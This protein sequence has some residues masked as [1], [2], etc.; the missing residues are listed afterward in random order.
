MGHKHHKEA[1]LN[2]QCWHANIK[3]KKQKSRFESVM[4]VMCAIQQE[5]QEQQQQQQQQEQEQ[6]QE[7]SMT[8]LYDLMIWLLLC[9]G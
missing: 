3:A 2:N 4:S 6:E 7:Q 1:K 9:I 8:L 5:Q